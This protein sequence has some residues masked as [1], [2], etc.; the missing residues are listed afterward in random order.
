[1][2]TKFVDIALVL[3]ALMLTVA[4]GVF[5]NAKAWGDNSP[6]L[7]RDSA[8]SDV[9]APLENPDLKGLR[10]YV[11]D[12]VKKARGQYNLPGVAVTIVKDGEIVLLKGYGFADVYSQAMAKPN[13]TLFRIGSITKT[14][15]ALAVMQ[16]VEQGKLSIDT[17]INEYLSEFK[18]PD[19]FKAP[20]TIRALLSHRAGFEEADAGNL[21]VENAS[22]MLSTER[23]LAT[24]MPKR[25]WPPGVNVSYSNY[26]FALLGYLVE[27]QSGMDL[28]TYMEQHIFSV[29][30]MQ[31][32]TLRE[33]VKTSAALTA[34]KPELQ[35][36]LATGYFRDRQ[37]NNIAKPFEFIGHVGGAGAISA[38]AHDMALYMSALMGD[39]NLFVQPTTQKTMIHRLYDDRP[40]AT[41]IAHGMFNGKLKGYEQRYHS[42]ATQTFAANMVIFPEVQLGIFV[43]TNVMGSGAH[44][45]EALP[46]AILNK[47]YRNK[48]INLVKPSQLSTSSQAN[49]YTQVLKQQVSQP[50]L[51][52]YTGTFLSTRRSYTQLEKLAALDAAAEIA[53]DDQNRLVMMVAGNKIKL[54]H[55]EADVFQAGAR[56]APIFY[57]YRDGTG[58]VNRFS[59]SM[60]S[61]DYERV[62][63]LQSP[64]FFNLALAISSLLSL[65]TLLFSF[66]RARKS[67][68][69]DQLEKL[70]CFSS[71]MILAA[72]LGFILMNAGIVFDEY[73]FH[74][75]FPTVEVKLLLS[76]VI[77]IVLTTF[78]K[79]L[80]LPI[81][82][83]MSDL[84]WFYKI[85]Y[86]IFTLS[87]LSFIYAFWIWNAVGFNY[88]G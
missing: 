35:Q 51:E 87:C 73:Q 80:S 18:I 15:T 50:N 45:V 82:L 53:I 84:Y 47:F 70:A 57:F 59:A 39:N 76:L 88:F 52:D 72:V 81:M 67:K 37:G 3:R 5:F 69:L 56:D 68:R 60:W 2:K 11:D 58:T 54:K 75:S 7:L 14:M 1:M 61:G 55:L 17:D 34:M 10:T 43:S 28:A 30:G 27:L 31:N 12:W 23:Y 83:R 86:V 42:G 16:L 48:P 29:L 74:A 62:S 65:S 64:L 32:T 21:F 20:I 63:F 79:V 25:I 8:V 44:F 41:G 26:G 40:L 19:T 71:S 46:T 78:L 22:E 77:A 66:V 13:K 4:I 9:Q 38:T 6:Q 49:I 85:H 33:P 24:H 36:Q